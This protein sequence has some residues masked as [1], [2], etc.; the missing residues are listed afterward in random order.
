MARPP[1]TNSGIPTNVSRSV[2]CMVIFI[3]PQHRIPLPPIL[4]MTY[5]LRLIAH[6]IILALGATGG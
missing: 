3:H 2:F 4:E 1:S 6:W 5:R